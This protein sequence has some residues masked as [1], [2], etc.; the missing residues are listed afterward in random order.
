MTVIVAH[1][2]ACGFFFL[3]WALRCTGDGYQETWLDVLE[4][5]KLQLPGC[6]A[7][8]SV[9]GMNMSAFELL[10]GSN[11]NPVWHDLWG[12]IALCTAFERL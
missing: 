2:F 12:N 10:D 4:H 5:P 3:G 8:M 11:G 7:T 6:P 1:C 9:S